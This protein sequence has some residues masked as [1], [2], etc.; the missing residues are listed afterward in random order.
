MK[1]RDFAFRYKDRNLVQLLNI[2]GKLYHVCIRGINLSKPADTMALH[3]YFNVCFAALAMWRRLS[4]IV[5]RSAVKRSH[6]KAA[7]VISFDFIAC[8]VLLKRIVPFN[9]FILFKGIVFHMVRDMQYSFKDGPERELED[10][11]VDERETMF[12]GPGGL[13]SLQGHEHCQKLLGSE[14]VLVDST[15]VWKGLEE[16]QN[17]IDYVGASCFPPQLEAA[18]EHST[19]NERYRFLACLVKAEKDYLATRELHIH[20]NMEGENAQLD[21]RKLDQKYETSSQFSRRCEFC[22]KSKDDHPYIGDIC[23][24]CQFSVQFPDKRIQDLCDDS[25]N[26]LGFGWNSMVCSICINI[27]EVVALSVI[28]RQKTGKYFDCGISHDFED[29]MAKRVYDEEEMRRAEQYFDEQTRK[30]HA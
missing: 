13:G 29:F 8:H 18:K 11:E 2:L 22:T 1:F 27:V 23:T 26:G 6:I 21:T 10:G 24:I 4:T 5:N 17:V 20:D 7:L 25:V 14:Q 19:D 16:K 30:A 15:N 12:L 3:H 9:T 28:H